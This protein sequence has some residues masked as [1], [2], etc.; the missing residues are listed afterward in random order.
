M[1]IYAHLGISACLCCP[2]HKG[3]AYGL[4]GMVQ[5][6]P[7][8]MQLHRLLFRIVDESDYKRRSKGKNENKR[9]N[10]SPEKFRK[11]GRGYEII[12]FISYQMA[13]SVHY[14]PDQMNP[15]LLAD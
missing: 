9:P 4:R 10:S 11:P 1:C 12:D 2:T 7:L 13:R 14:D 5:G 15:I 3:T 8:H 6:P